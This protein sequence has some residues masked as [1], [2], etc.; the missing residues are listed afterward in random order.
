M[1]GPTEI[2]K[3]NNYPF[4]TLCTTILI[5]FLKQYLHFI[6]SA[7]Y[8]IHPCSIT[9]L[10]CNKCAPNKKIKTYKIKKRER[11]MMISSHD[12][13]SP[14]TRCSANLVPRALRLRSSRLD[15]SHSSGA[16]HAEG[17]GDE[18]EEQLQRS[19]GMRPVHY[20]LSHM[21]CNVILTHYLFD[22]AYNCEDTQW[23]RSNFRGKSDI[24]FVLVMN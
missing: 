22:D 9:G 3:P 5:R 1:Y 23:S 20:L 17:P 15:Q 2:Q 7:Y 6:Q 4:A 19:L 14:T 13:I 11:C 8:C 18:V 24:R 12:N 21:K 10:C 16:S